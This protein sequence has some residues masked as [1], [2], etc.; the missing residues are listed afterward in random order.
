MMDKNAPSV[1]IIQHPD[2]RRQLIMMKVYVE[3]IRSLLYYV[4]M[5]EDQVKICED[6]E[7]KSKYQGIID[8]LIPI[9]KGYATDRAFEVCSHGV[10]VYGGYGY[11]RDYPMEQLLRDCRITMIYEGTNGIQAMDL[12]G[13]KLGLNKGKPMMDL[14]GEIQKSIAMAKDAQGLEDFADR[15]EA[16]VNKLG[17]VALHMGMTAMS[18]KVMNAFA[19]AHPFME[20]CGDV[21][22]AWM[23]LWRAAIASKKLEEGAKKK[24]AAF[25][26]GQIKS[27]EFFIYSIIPITVGKIKA[28]LTTNGAAVEIDEKSFGG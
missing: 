24:D 1:P 22:M 7:E 3:G 15:L 27:A 14:L 26:Q 21:V 12:L 5:C 18:P 25:Y 23:L 9:A 2:V 16:A 17:E 19:F 11:I 13:R 8:V 6:A 4:G 20:V 28:I 10:Q